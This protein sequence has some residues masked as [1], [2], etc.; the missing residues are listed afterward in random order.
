MAPPPPQTPGPHDPE[1][2]LT[3]VKGGCH[4]SPHSVP[5]LFT[6]SGPGVFGQG[7]RLRGVV[8]LGVQ[9]GVHYLKRNFLGGR[10]PMD[11]RQANRD[12]RRWCLTTAGQR[13]NYHEAPDLDREGCI[14]SVEHAYSQDGGL[15]VLFGN[16]SGAASSRPPASTS[17]S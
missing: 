6:Q 3:K 2:R 10:E 17:R 8:L 5:P 7:A 15:A 13:A 16:L 9:V 14:R 11:V 12:V 1:A 4:L